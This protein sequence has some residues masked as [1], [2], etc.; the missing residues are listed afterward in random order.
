MSLSCNNVLTS[1]SAIYGSE[2]TKD[3]EEW[4]SYKYY[5]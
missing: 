5:K 1:F 2:A 4:Q 3:K